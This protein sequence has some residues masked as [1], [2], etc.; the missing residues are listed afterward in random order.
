MTTRKKPKRKTFTFQNHSCIVNDARGSL[1]FVGAKHV[2][3]KTMTGLNEF[4]KQGIMCDVVLK[5]DNYEI[6]A[7]RTVLAVHSEYF[8]AMFTTG[9]VESREKEI[10]IQGI[11]NKSLETLIGYMYTGSLDVTKETV[12]D[13]LTAACM[14]QVED[15]KDIC[16]NSLLRFVDVSN[17]ISVWMFSDLHSLRELQIKSS[18]LLKSRFPAIIVQEEFLLLESNKLMEI[19]AFDDLSLGIKNEDTVLEGIVRWLE[20]DPISRIQDISELLK[21]VRLHLVSMPYLQTVRQHSVVIDNHDAVSLIDNAIAIKEDKSP[22]N[23]KGA[24]QPSSSIY[25]LG[26]YLQSRTGGNCP[27]T[28]SVEKY[29]INKDKWTEVGKLPFNLECQTAVVLNGEMFFVHKKLIQPKL[30]IPTFTNVGTVYTLC[31]FSSLYNE[32]KLKEISQYSVWAHLRDFKQCAIAVC[33]DENVVYVCGGKEPTRSLTAKSVLRLDIENDCWTELPSLPELRFNHSAIVVNRRLYVIGGNDISVHIGNHRQEVKS[34]VFMYDPDEGCWSEK[35]EM[36]THRLGLGLAE[37]GGF[38]YAV[39]GVSN[40]TRERS[41]E[42]YDPDTDCWNYVCDMN[43]PRSF[44]SV[45]ACHG[46][47]YAIG[48]KSYSG[49]CGGAR[50]VVRSGEVYNPATDTWTMIDSMKTPR[51]MMSACVL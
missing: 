25:V 33:K 29:D 1:K 5:V 43:K 40:V 39:G 15:V 28:L 35:C 20:H 6:P 44:L 16:S 11:E 18:Q 24:R 12:Q 45:V 41:V 2:T 10:D 49:D 8:R 37:V 7:H 36:N 17:C 42:K 34:S 32:W 48:G 3:K 46:L 51:C 31:T 21:L 23:L 9:M 22:H 27:H 30:K 19:L 4:R 14:L 50:T 13:L 47:L 26:G 38:L